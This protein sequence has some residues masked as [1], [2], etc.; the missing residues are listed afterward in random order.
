MIAAVK[1]N[2]IIL[3]TC[4]ILLCVLGTLCITG[5]ISTAQN[6]ALGMTVVVD[7]G[8]GGIDS[9][10]VGVSTGVKESDLNLVYANVLGQYLKR[11]GI[12]VVYTRSTENGL[13]SVF[14]RNYKQ[15]D[16]QVRQKIINDAKAN[17]VISIHMNTYP[18]SSERG[19]QA[20]YDKTAS[21]GKLMAESIQKQLRANIEYARKEAIAGDYY[22]LNCTSVPSALVECGFLSNPQEEALLVDEKYQKKLCYYIYCGIIQY[23]GVV[24]KVAV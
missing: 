19:A 13:Y 20:F 4:I 12:K 23:L 7:A 10:C 9:G 2:T 21:Q 17:L 11:A 6:S 3:V 1:K 22:I 18:V 8:H 16:M 5:V 24:S 14:G 15:E